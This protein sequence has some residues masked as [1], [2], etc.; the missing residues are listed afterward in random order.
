MTARH[1]LLALLGIGL[2]LPERADAQ[3]SS[4]GAAKRRADQ[5]QPRVIPVREVPHSSR[6]AVYDQYAW[7]SL[8]P[9]TA[10]TFKPGDLLTIVVREQRTFE[11]DADLETKRK[12]DVKSELDAF[13]KPTAGGIGSAGFRRGKPNIQYK[14]D[15][16]LKTESDTS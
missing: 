14:L 10:K 1:L 5:G 16:K 9:V 7:I 8:T 11:A 4:L 6:S 12:Y 3:T 2:G 15:H 13:I